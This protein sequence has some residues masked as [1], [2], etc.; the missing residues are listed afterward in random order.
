MAKLDLNTALKG[1]HGR[2]DGWVYRQ[3][4]G[5][6][7]IGP[8]PVF[9]KPPTAGQ[10][11]FKERF[12]EATAYGRAALA[13]PV[14]GPL[15]LAKARTRKL[16]TFAVIIADYFKS[17]EVKSIDTVDYHGHIGDPVKVTAIDDFEVVGVNV[18][19]RDDTDAVL[20]QG[21][22]VLT[23]EKW[24]YTAT[25]AVP[26]GEAVTIEATAKDRPGHTG[27]LIKPWLIA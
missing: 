20:E 4:N 19:I 22:A 25:V 16:P 9:T 11:A 27:A 13:D 3:V 23:G 24:T 5:R 21:A 17:P 15:Y 12:K 6:T 7:V 14:A 18:V 1:L 2:V 26:V 10:L 8:K